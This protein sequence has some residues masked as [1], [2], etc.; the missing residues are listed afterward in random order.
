MI[1]TSKKEFRA[2][3]E[4]GRILASI[5]KNLKEAVEPGKSA[6]E[7]DKLARELTQGW[8]ATLAFEG[9]Q[10]FPD[11]LCVSINDQVAHGT[12]GSDKIFKEGDLVSLDFGVVYEGFYTDH[13]ISFG[14][15]E[16]THED[17]ALIDV[18]AQALEEGIQAV[19]AGA[20]TGDIGYAIEQFVKS[21]GKFG[22]VH[23]LVGHGIGR[24]I[25]EEP[26]I[27]NFGMQGS[28]Y[29]LSEGEVIA[30]EPMVTLGSEMVE[31]ADDNFTYKTSDGSR[32]A[33]FE[34]TMIVG[35][36]GA[37]VIT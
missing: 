28:G 27:P 9:Y 4:A 32:A 21:K 33:H 12:S 26:K 2:F 20:R 37:E 6:R 31:L 5:M 7:I 11:A 22:V 16:L 10:G 18:T 13:A 1:I 36:K 14:L 35:K 29:Q 25:H 23:R 3:R 30:I 34:K 19:K 24:K 17:S 15:G 8:G